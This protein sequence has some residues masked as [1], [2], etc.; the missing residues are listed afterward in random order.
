MKKWLVI[1]VLMLPAVALIGQS[2]EEAIVRGQFLAPAV[3]MGEL[4]GDVSLSLGVSGGIDFRHYTIG[5]F[6][7]RTQNLY[8][9]ELGH[10]AYDIELLY[11]GLWGQA[12]H[13]ISSQ[14]RLFGGM[15]AAYGQA[16][17]SWDDEAPDRYDPRD[18]LWIAMPEFGMEFVLT[19]QISL[20][21]F[22]GYRFCVGVDDLVGLR[23]RDFNSLVNGLTLRIGPRRWNDSD[24]NQYARLTNITRPGPQGR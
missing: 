16:R 22:S 21:I 10:D 2:L 18:P 14:V 11:G 7:M 17:V 3:E 12:T 9:F 20:T 15:R 19:P 4:R 5:F 13:M 8:Q 6:G 23:N 24:K 1:L